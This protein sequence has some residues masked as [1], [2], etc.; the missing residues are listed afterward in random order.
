MKVN[1]YIETSS[2]APRV[3]HASGI[4]LLE[5][6]EDDG[7]PVIV[8]GEP[9]VV[10][11]RMDF[12]HTNSNTMTLTLLEAAL[13]RMQKSATLQVFTKCEAVFWTLKNRWIT[14]WQE[15]GWKNAKGMSVKYEENWRRIAELLDKYDWSVSQEHHAWEK[16]MQQELKGGNRNVG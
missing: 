7:K 16:W 15:N 6:L 12:E 2:V 10:Y 9:W 1:I 14:T 5:A 3:L 11:E 4:Y 13:K 8:K